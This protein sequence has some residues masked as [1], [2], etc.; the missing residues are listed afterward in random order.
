MGSHDPFGHLQHKLWPK[1]RPGVSLTPDHGKSRID[2]IPLCSGG[3]QHV[4]EKLS[5]RATT[6]V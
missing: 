3:V 6:L 5:I 4:V 2:P 1:E